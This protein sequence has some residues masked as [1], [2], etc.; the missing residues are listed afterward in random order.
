MKITAN[1][2]PFS[3]VVGGGIMLLDESG[4]CIGQLSLRGF[5]PGSSVSV[6]ELRKASNAMCEQ[7]AAAI[8]GAKVERRVHHAGRDT[9]YDVLPTAL[10]QVSRGDMGLDGPM[11][12]V[13]DGDEVVVYRNRDGKHFVR[14][15]DEMVEPRFKEI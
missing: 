10:F 11:C 12:L 9:N 5:P 13:R 8:N 1:P 14:F 3:S 6:E 4:A 2:V 15:A 7:I